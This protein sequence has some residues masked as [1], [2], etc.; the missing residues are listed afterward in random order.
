M[1]VD[2]LNSNNYITINISLISI[3]GLKEAVYVSELLNILKKAMIKNKM[4]EDVYV[5]VN[6]KFISDRTTISQNEQRE[7]D[8]K[9]NS[10]DLLTIHNNEKDIISLN[11]TGIA[12]LIAFNGDKCEKDTLSAIE[13]NFKSSTKSE[14]DK[15][16]AKAI[17]KQ[18]KN[19]IN[20]DNKNIK[21]HLRMWIDSVIKTNIVTIEIVNEFQKAV[22]LY[23][24]D[25][26]E[27][28]K[29]IDIATANSYIY[30]ELAIKKYEEEIKKNLNSVR[31]TDQKKATKDDLMEG[32]EF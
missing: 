13:N 5:K 8:T 10:M 31:V 21:H 7:I 22:K 29:V 26:E 20:I 16:K 2:L 17:A 1:Y 18:L 3:M 9:L 25:E 23:S 14:M 12:S 30:A 19:H 15:V 6:R 32:V 28:I 27:V 4:I 24:L 11:V